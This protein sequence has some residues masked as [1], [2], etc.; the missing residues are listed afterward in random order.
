MMTVDKNMSPEISMIPTCFGLSGLR[1][2][3]NLGLITAACLHSATLTGGI[4]N[5]WRGPID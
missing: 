4:G 5:R 3:E 2:V 1:L